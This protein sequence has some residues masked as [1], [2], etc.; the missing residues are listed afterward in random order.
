AA[1]LAPF[2]GILRDEL[3]VKSVEL[4]ELDEDV[5]DRY[6]ISKRLTV[7]ARAAGPRLGKQVQHVIAGARAGVWE[8]IDGA[9]VVDGVALQEGEYE[10]TLEAGGA[11][12][13]IAIALLPEGGFVLLDTATTP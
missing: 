2:D 8:E 5:A 13:G 3:N 7:N 6:G 9:I 1:S 4:I 12:E 10:L 11:G